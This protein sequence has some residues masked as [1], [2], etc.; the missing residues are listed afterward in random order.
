MPLWIS[1]RGYKKNH[2]ENTLG[3]F[4]DAVSRG[5]SC[6]ET[7]LR[8]SRDGHIVLSH[9][10]NLSRTWGV[11]EEICALSRT[12]LESVVHPNGDRLLF[13]EKFVNEF[14]SCSW[15]FDIKPE[16]GADTIT[17]LVAWAKSHGLMERLNENTTFLLWK[18]SH[19]AQLKKLL[20]SSCLYAGKKECRIAGLSVLCRLPLLGQIE[21]G[22]TYSLPP[23]IA[24]LN[25]FQ[26][27]FADAFHQKR[28]K[29]LA[30]LPQTQDDIKAALD[31]GFDEILTD[32]EIAYSSCL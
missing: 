19:K 26:K 21:Q 11:Q 9:D 15:V 32:G 28:A 18:D 22:K 23:T 8:T 24:G 2:A 27:R 25:L 12:E 4:R 13:L 20:P 6:L 31:A 14:G 7:D 30:F 17:T 16:Q 29:V 3:A 10:S 1:H 5:F